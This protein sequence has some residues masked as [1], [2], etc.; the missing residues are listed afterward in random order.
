VG[1]LELVDSSYGSDKAGL[2]CAYTFAA[3]KGGRPLN[4]REAAERLAA[5]ADWDTEFVWLH[6][7]L[8]NA[9]SEPWL[10]EHAALPEAFY[11]LLKEKPSTRLEAVGDALFAVVND[12]QFFAYEAS[13]ASTVTLYVDQHVMVSARATPLRSPAAKAGSG[14]WSSS[15]S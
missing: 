10:R 12:V 14:A 4:S 13:S 8:T 5:D 6:L 11:D 2:V 15:S 1:E 3:G 9:A 7:S